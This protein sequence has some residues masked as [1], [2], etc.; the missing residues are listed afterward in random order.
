MT[1]KYSTIGGIPGEGFHSQRVLGFALNDF[2]GTIVI[3]AI[4]SYF[5]K[6]SF[7]FSFIG[8]FVLGEILHYLFCVDTAFIKLFK[9]KEKPKEVIKLKLNP[10]T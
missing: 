8:W 3:A 9:S 7:L 6:I 1:C 5:T 10:K 4:F 2:I